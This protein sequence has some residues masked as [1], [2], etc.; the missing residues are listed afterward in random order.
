MSNTSELATNRDTTEEFWL[1]GNDI[2]VLLIHGFSGSPAEMRYLGDML[3]QRGYSVLGV[4]LAGHGTNTAEMAETGYKDW[5]E[6]AEGAFDRLSGKCSKVFVVGFSMGSL[7]ALKIAEDGK[8]VSGVVAISPPMYTSLYMR[9]LSW[10]ITFWPGKTFTIGALSS[11][12]DS[13]DGYKVVT[14]EKVP[15]R[16]ILDLLAIV[17]LVR[18]S[19][20]KVNVPVLVLQGGMDVIIPESSGREIITGVESVNKKLI[21][22]PLSTHVVPMGIDRDRVVDLVSGFLEANDGNKE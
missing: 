13:K 21:R 7:L 14:Y 5:I 3:N 6:S 17:N 22:L 1:P 12:L 15:K 18:K 16:K 8:K 4:R 20:S 19:L 11:F 9:V 2:G 10:W